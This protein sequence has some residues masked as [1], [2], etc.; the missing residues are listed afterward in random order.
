LALKLYVDDKGTLGGLNIYSTTTEEI[1]DG[2]VSMATLF[3]A[4]AATAMG[5]ASEVEHLHEALSTRTV[6]GVAVG[7]L[8]EQYTLSQDAA[9]GLMVRSSSYSN[10]K[11]R[12]IARRMVDEANARAVR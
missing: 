12:D 8:M 3:A 6:I 1:D 10:I 5:N 9:F 2:A 7:M 11:L 4:H